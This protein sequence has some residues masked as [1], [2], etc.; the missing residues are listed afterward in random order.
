[1][2]DADNRTPLHYA[3]AAGSLECADV[4]LAH[5]ADVDVN[6]REWSVGRT[7]L[8]CASAANAADVCALLLRTG[9]CPLLQDLRGLS[10]EQLA[11]LADAAAAV[12]VLRAS[13]APIAYIEVG[14]DEPTLRFLRP[15]TSMIPVVVAGT[16]DSLVGRL[17]YIEHPDLEF[18]RTFL[19]TY[20]AFTTARKL[21]AEL[22][23][24]YDRSPTEAD[25]AGSLVFHSP[26]D[27]DAMQER[28]KMKR[29]R[30][31][32]VMH[33]WT[34]GT[35]LNY[36]PEL[37]EDTDVLRGMLDFADAV[38]ASPS[39]PI[40]GVQILRQQVIALLQ[41]TQR[42]S[43]AAVAAAPAADAGR[44]GDTDG[45]AA[46]D[47][48]YIR[49]HFARSDEWSTVALK[50]DMV[51]AD[52]VEQQCRRRLLVPAEHCI[53]LAGSGMPLPDAEPMR[54]FEGATLRIRPVRAGES[55]YLEDMDPDLVAEQLTSMDH[56]TL[57]AVRPIEWRYQNWSKRPQLAPN[58]A[59]L[60]D[61]FNRVSAWCAQLILGGAAPEARA[62]A[63]EKTIG[64]AKRCRRL[65]NFHGTLQVVSALKFAPIARLKQS[66]AL[67]SAEQ[68]A[69]FEALCEI[70]S[71]SDNR[72]KYRAA[73][74]LCN[75]PCVPYLGLHLSDLVF[76]EQGNATFLDDARTGDAPDGEADVDTEA[77]IR[78]ANAG[79]PINF[80]KFRRLA[81]VYEDMRRYLVRPRAPRPAPPHRLAR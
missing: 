71:P 68:R 49:V 37:V 77:A 33:K 2:R 19:M 54:P 43:G 6:R 36:D 29:L 79:R 44:S 80:Q 56:R 21:F 42:E 52:V 66:W 23:A 18:T 8:H 73:L 76:I 30:V 65:N 34:S 41:Q 26:N 45:E 62:R 31:L 46:P 39:A 74:R 48:R 11:V 78:A 70:A 58:L 35:K 69:A 63:I 5:G 55:A 47:G 64:I 4:L 15:Q 27:A 38:A 3:C 14:V 60:T 40:G 28:M 61:R 17:V 7:P 50:P 32:S 59:R 75:P 1:M 72:A 25:S 51:A 20:R 16:V 22:R 13:P 81:Q 67:V 53:M 24:H 10:A 9:A 12:R 57:L